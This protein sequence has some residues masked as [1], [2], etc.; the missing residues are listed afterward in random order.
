MAMAQNDHRYKIYNSSFDNIYNIA[1]F[2]VMQ[3]NVIEPD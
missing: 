1:E 2:N 3:A